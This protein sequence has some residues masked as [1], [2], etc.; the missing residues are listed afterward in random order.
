MEINTE[1]ATTPIPSPFWPCPNNCVRWARAINLN[2]P[3]TNHH[4]RCEHVA[5]SLI[6]VW[7]VSYDGG[8]YVIDKP[9]LTTHPRETVT[10]EKMHREIY[11]RLPEFQG[12]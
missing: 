1:Q 9:P 10:T 12:F 5:A 11:E 8:S 7:R 4:P 3:M 2:E 6:E